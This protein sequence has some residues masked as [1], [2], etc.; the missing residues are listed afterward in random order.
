MGGATFLSILLES[1]CNPWHAHVANAGRYLS[2]LLESYCNEVA[3]KSMKREV[4]PFNS[5]R[6]L[7]QLTRFKLCLNE[8]ILSILLESYCN[9]EKLDQKL[10]QRDAFNSPRVLL[11]PGFPS[12]PRRRSWSRLSILLE[13]YCNLADEDEEE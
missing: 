11:Q 6:V 10:D 8:Y 4:K 12:P 3:V 9:L 1:Y 5:P 13:S 7:L 2:I